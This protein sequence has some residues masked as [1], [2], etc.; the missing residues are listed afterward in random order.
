MDL[1]KLEDYY[2]QALAARAVADHADGRGGTYQFWKT[3]SDAYEQCWQ[4]LQGRDDS[5]PPVLT[6]EW[7]EKME[8]RL[9][10]VCRG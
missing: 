1:A 5:D 4:L 9:S 10:D 7:K 6:P 3:R 2:A 8:K